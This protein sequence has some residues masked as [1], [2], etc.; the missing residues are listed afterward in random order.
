MGLD[1]DLFFCRLRGGSRSISQVAALA[2][3]VPG[4]RGLFH[5][6]VN[7]G[8][9]KG[10]ERSRLGVGQSRFSFALGKRPV[11]AVGPNQQELNA[12][13]ADPVA[14]SGDLFATTELAKLRQSKEFRCRPIR[15]GPPVGGQMRF[16]VIRSISTHSRRVHDP[17]CVWLE[18]TLVLGD[19]RSGGWTYLRSIPRESFCVLAMIEGWRQYLLLAA[20]AR[21]EDRWNTCIVFAVIGNSKPDTNRLRYIC[22]RRL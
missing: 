15:P 10:F 17:V 16:G 18:H 13:C 9:F 8:L 22:S 3:N 7:S 2:T 19:C 1:D 5:P 20:T 12:V 4:K 14:N 11:S 21:Q 6:S